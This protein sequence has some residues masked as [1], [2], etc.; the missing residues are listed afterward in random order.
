MHA[1]GMGYI[2]SRPMLE[3]LQPYLLKC[4]REAPF[5][6][7]DIEIACCIYGYMGSSIIGPNHSVMMA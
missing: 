4:L 6:V 3:K 7:E 5:L 2:L 1:G